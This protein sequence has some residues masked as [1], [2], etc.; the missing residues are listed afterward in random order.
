MTTQRITTL[1]LVLSLAFA[2]FSSRGADYD[3]TR[4]TAGLNDA[5]LPLL[6][7]EV[8]VASLSKDTAQ[9][10]TLT[11]ASP[12]HDGQASELRQLR[13]SVH[14]R[15]AGSLLLNKKSFAVTTIDSSGEEL[16]TALFGLREA[17]SFILDA[18]GYDR[19]RMRN[20]VCFDLWNSF[21]RTP[22]STNYNGCNGT[23]GVMVELFLNGNYH[24]IYCLSDKINRSLLGLKKTKNASQP[25][26]VLYKSFT[27]G[28]TSHLE[29]YGQD[30]PLTN[31]TWGCW[32]LK[33]PEDMPS[34][35][36]WQPLLDIIDFFATDDTTYIAQHLDD[37]IWREN[38]ADY[39]IFFHI[40]AL[41]DNNIKNSYL[42]SRDLSSGEQ[43]LML[44]PWDLDGS[45]G[46]ESNGEYNTNN[47]SG[48]TQLLCQVKPYYLLFQQNVGGFRELMK[49]RWVE[50]RDGALAPQNMEQLLDHYTEQLTQ[51][52][53]WQREVAKWN[54]DPLPLRDNLADET[55]IIK[56]WYAYAHT[57]LEAILFPKNGD[58]VQSDEWTVATVSRI[59][60]V[61]LGLVPYDESLDTNG[62]GTC[63]VTDVYTVFSHILGTQQAAPLP[64]N[65]N[66]QSA[67]AVT[68]K[69][70]AKTTANSSF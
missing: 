17:H 64:R 29:S 19:A 25:R 50:L 11:L 69:T 54:N 7:L 57:R 67:K 35:Q 39:A 66:R 58:P 9:L 49:Q 45:L 33:Q 31:D 46:A 44:T 30:W 22:Y 60:D 12:P 6:N 15:G 13:C 26:G 18:M 20:R 5:S 47:L 8:E 10:A 62:D 36:A 23:Q 68:T 40:V 27:H 63:S 34:Q 48:Q 70:T 24:G 61:V 38:W 14:Y 52:G 43:R 28:V 42:S 2:W 3:F 32:E 55:Q 59:F 4:L 51:S 1:L 53:A 65:G 16:D 41:R 21:S 56:D 37:Y